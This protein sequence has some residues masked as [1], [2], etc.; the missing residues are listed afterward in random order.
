MSAAGRRPRVAKKRTA[1]IRDSIPE[2]MSL[3]ASLHQL[4]RQRSPQPVGNRVATPASNSVMMEHPQSLYRTTTEEQTN[5][6]LSI[7][8]NI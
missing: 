1:A 5:V 3:R 4:D 6:Q 7:A 2:T 8:T